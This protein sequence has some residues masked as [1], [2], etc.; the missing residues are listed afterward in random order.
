MTQLLEKQLIDYAMDSENPIINYN[1][2]TTYDNMNQIASAI[3]HYL[4]CAER[5][6]DK[7][8]QYECL[9]LAGLAIQRQGS[10]VYTEKSFFQNAISVMPHRPE[11]YL[12]IADTFI[13][14]NNPHNAY[15]MLCIGEQYCKNPYMPLHAQIKYNGELDF[16]YKKIEAEQGCGIAHHD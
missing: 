11:A 7:L 14:M 9:L 12:F 3:S 5:T 13:R 4:R 1:I 2:A 10:R 6:E 16:K 15:M 8:L